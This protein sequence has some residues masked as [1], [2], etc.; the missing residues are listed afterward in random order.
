MLK[1]VPRAEEP[2]RVEP[3]VIRLDTLPDIVRKLRHTMDDIGAGH[4]VACFVTP[5]PERR[6]LVPCLDA[7]YPSLAEETTLL[8]AMLGNGFTRRIAKSSVPLWW[9]QTDNP[10]LM[11]MPDAVSLAERME[12]PAG[13]SAGLA[14]SVA[15]EHGPEGVIIFTGDKLRVTTDAL[16]DIHARCIGLFSVVAKLKPLSAN[17]TPPISK[18]ELECL[19]L[20]ANGLTSEEIAERLGLSV[21][22]ANQYLT[23]T[24]R[25]LNAMN[26]MQA[27]AKALRMG[28]FD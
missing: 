17:S 27:V 8:A 1:P 2:D 25:K 18:R 22:T 13:S 12:P 5:R 26:R 19:M 20:T 28:L 6:R 10:F 11:A 23:N 24:S 7:H 3:R 14:L 21:H 15:V 4:F 16:C 9:S